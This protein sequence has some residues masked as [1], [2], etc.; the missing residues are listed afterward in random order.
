MIQ[1]D[2]K[3]GNIITTCDKC[4]EVISRSIKNVGVI[5]KPY[6]HKC[7]EVDKTI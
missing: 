5:G 2:E 6:S 3:T 7:I 4:K 1:I